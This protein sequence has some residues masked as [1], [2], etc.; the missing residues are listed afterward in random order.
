MNTFWKNYA[1]SFWKDKFFWKIVK[2][3]SYTDEEIRKWSH[4]LKIAKDHLTKDNLIQRK[5]YLK[6]CGYDLDQE[7]FDIGYSKPL[8]VFL[9][10]EGLNENIFKLQIGTSIE[11]FKKRENILEDYNNKFSYEKLKTKYKKKKILDDFAANGR[12]ALNWWDDWGY[13]VRSNFSK[14]PKEK[15][16]LFITEIGNDSCKQYNNKDACLSIFRDQIK[17]YQTPLYSDPQLSLLDTNIGVKP[18]YAIIQIVLGLKEKYIDKRE[19]ILFVNKVRN[20]EE[21]TINKVINLIEEFRKLKEKQKKEIVDYI[22]HKD[23]S[24]RDRNKKSKIYQ[25]TSE[26][27][28]KSIQ[29]FMN[30]SGDLFVSDNNVNN[31]SYNLPENKKDLA[32]KIIKK[33]KENPAK[34]YHGFINKYEYNLAIGKREYENI[35]EILKRNY[36]SI[37]PSTISKF[38]KG[39]ISKKEINTKQKRVLL[40]LSIQKYFEKNIEILN[41]KYDLKLEILK[42]PGSKARKTLEFDTYVVG[43][44]DLL[45]K[46]RISGKYYVIE[47]KRDEADGDTLGQIMQYMGWVSKEYK[48]TPKGIVICYHQSEKYSFAT[49]Y[50]KNHVGELKDIDIHTHDFTDENP[51][52]KN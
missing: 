42:R 22:K 11:R 2:A 20:H 48:T 39:G 38:Y 15:N 45:C 27:S 18:Y 10:C 7:S 4:L 23:P 41:K 19:Y 28:D 35:D 44:I 33:F 26:N 37:N 30:Y 46:D 43:E 5:K 13:A 25:T 36:F 40:E 31:I 50:I 17:K 21:K 9:T 3:K 49:S 14:N 32:I 8:E 24:Q 29:A 1:K 52:P 12:N 6:F 34:Q 16:Y 47:I 51:P